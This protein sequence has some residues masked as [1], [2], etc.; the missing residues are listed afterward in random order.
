MQ[1]IRVTTQLTADQKEKL[2]ELAYKT[3]RSEAEL[4]REAVG[5]YTARMGGD[6]LDGCG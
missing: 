6:K 5:K 4:I 2:R 3:R 1:Y